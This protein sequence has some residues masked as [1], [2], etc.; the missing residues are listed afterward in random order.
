MMR[1]SLLSL[2]IVMATRPQA[3]YV[4][5]RSFHAPHQ[6]P[7]SVLCTTLASRTYPLSMSTTTALLDRLLC[8]SLILQLKEVR[9]NV[10]WLLAS[11]E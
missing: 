1:L 9:Y 10:P 6:V 11:K 5:H 2:D 4:L 7:L 3:K 8:I